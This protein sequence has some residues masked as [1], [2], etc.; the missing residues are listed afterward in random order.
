MAAA[1]IG[2]GSAVAAP[3]EIVAMEPDRF[4]AIIDGTTKLEGDSERQLAALSKALN[5]LS[6]A[7]IQRFEAAFDATMRRSY[8]WDFWA[9]DY[10]AHGGASDDSFEYFRCWLISKGRV[11]FEYVLA[12]PDSLADSLAPDLHGVLEFEDFAYVA[13]EVWSQ[14]ARPPGQEMP[15]TAPMMYVGVEPSGTPF[16]EDDAELARRLPRLWKRFGEKPLGLE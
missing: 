6:L 11:I 16:A 5:R 3:G 15:N 8:N 12:N 13:R 9:A 10:V 4:W 2:P 14:K 7:D 1:L